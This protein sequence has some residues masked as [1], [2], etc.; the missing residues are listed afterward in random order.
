[1]LILFIL[2]FAQKQIIYAAMDEIR[3]SFWGQ[4]HPL[5]TTENSI[6][7]YTP[8]FIQLNT[9]FVCRP[10]RAL[11]LSRGPRKQITYA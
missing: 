8:L 11:I 6:A 10:K 3:V 9:P 1:M 2:D 7:F 5:L 4:Y